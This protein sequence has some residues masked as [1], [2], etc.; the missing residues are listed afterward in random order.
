MKEVTL[1][2]IE[3]KDGS[4]TVKF[5]PTV[6]QMLKVAVACQKENRMVPSTIVYALEAAKSLQEKSSK[7]LRDSLK[8]APTEA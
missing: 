7:T 5:K 3:L 6:E 8:V 1:K 2:I 4:V